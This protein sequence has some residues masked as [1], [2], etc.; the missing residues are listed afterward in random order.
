MPLYRGHVAERWF[1]AE[2]TGVGGRLLEGRAGT[3][4]RPD[5]HRP[6]SLGLPTTIILGWPDPPQHPD[7][8]ASV[9]EWTIT[10]NVPV[11]AIRSAFLVVGCTRYY[12]GLHS[13]EF[14]GRV[15]I[16]V[17]GETIDGFGLRKSHPDHSDYFH[18]PTLPQLPELGRD[19]DRCQT[20]YAW[21][22]R[23]ELLDDRAQVVRL[24]V[25]GDTRWDVDRVAILLEREQLHDVFLSHSWADKPLA[26]RLAND[27]REH[28]I[29]VWLDEAEM[30]IGDSLIEKIGAAIESVE[31]V[32][33]LLSRDSVQSSWVQRELEIAITHQINGRDLTVL[34]I[35][36]DDCQ[37]PPFLVGRLYSD[38]RSQD[39]Y[40][41][42]LEELRRRIQS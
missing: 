18:R 7:R 26:R 5:G 38:L 13:R 29:A 33:A 23:P 11:A 41:E 20:L 22:I 15:T 6:E 42:I 10:T 30:A 24:R 28:D 35:V 4:D 16:H 3:R 32:L 2:S 8:A 17:N 36:V 25:D 9:V 40:P 27:L 39:R 21:P 1:R 37:I 14:D 34:P 31:F 12:G 19:L